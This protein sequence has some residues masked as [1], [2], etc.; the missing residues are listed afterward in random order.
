MLVGGEQDEPNET[1][2]TKTVTANNLEVQI[3]VGSIKAPC[4]KEENKLWLSMDENVQL[5]SYYNERL[6][7]GLL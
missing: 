4:N 6:D 5:F 2:A 3:K 1:K 7:L